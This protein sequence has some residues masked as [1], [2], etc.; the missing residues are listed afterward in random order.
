MSKTDELIASQSRVVYNL[1]KKQ[2]ANRVPEAVAVPQVELELGVMLKAMKH[3]AGSSV[4][5]EMQNLEATNEDLVKEVGEL[6]AKVEELESGDGPDVAELESKISA[7]E[8]NVQDLAKE[9]EKLLAKITELEEKVP[10]EDPETP[11]SE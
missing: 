8:V 4:K 1:V 11:D 6:T 9:R 10:V 5:T 7:L 2:V 3:S